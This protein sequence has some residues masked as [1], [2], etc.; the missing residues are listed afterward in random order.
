MKTMMT[1]M[2]LSLT[3][4]A[5]AQSDWRR[6]KDYEQQND[7]PAVHTCFARDAFSQMYKESASSEVKASKAALHA[8]EADPEQGPCVILKCEVE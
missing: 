5:M 8:C 7:A 4:S 2:F 6:V 3:L 1:A